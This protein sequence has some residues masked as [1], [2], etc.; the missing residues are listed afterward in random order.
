M[1]GSVANVPYWVIALVVVVVFATIAA[2]VIHGRRPPEAAHPVLVGAGDIATCHNEIDE[3]TARLLKNVPGTVFTLGDN[4]YPSGTPRQYENCYEPTWGRHKARTQA[5]RRQPRVRHGQRVGLLRLLRRRRRRRRP[6]ATTA[7]TYGAWHVI[8][9]NSMCANVGGCG[10]GSPR[11]SWLQADL[12]ANPTSSARWPT[13]TT[14]A[15]ARPRARQRPRS[16]Q[17]LWQALY[18]ANADL[19][20]TGH[21]H[22]Y[23]RFAP[24]DAR[25]QRS[26]RERGIREFVVG[27]GGRSHYVHSARIEPNSEV[28]NGDTYGVIKLR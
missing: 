1:R 28:R 20:L 17:P 3:A 22:D 14:R 8:V 21:D 19:V 9:L 10:A 27:T 15:S 6:R 5:R 26:T 12:A 18:D 13:G 16:A 24:A 7:T 11:L 2:L 4:A 23:E 25:R